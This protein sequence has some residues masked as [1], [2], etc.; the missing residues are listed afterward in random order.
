MEGQMGF[1]TKY[2]SA[3]R[4]DIMVALKKGGRMNAF[5]STFFN[6]KSLL[7]KAL[8]YYFGFIR[9]LPDEP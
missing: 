5:E 6:L 2:L 1:E 4:R 3:G 9:H 8:S 7:L